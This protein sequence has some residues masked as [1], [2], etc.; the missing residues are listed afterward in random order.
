MLYVLEA[1]GSLPLGPAHCTYAVRVPASGVPYVPRTVAP[2]AA[3]HF[4][5]EDSALRR[6]MELV[7]TSY[8]AAAISRRC[9]R[10]SNSGAAP[11][12]PAAGKASRFQTCAVQPGR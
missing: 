2:Q 12:A 8:G 7:A 9:V 3:G 11:A 10:E 4:F 6:D 5:H 1:Q